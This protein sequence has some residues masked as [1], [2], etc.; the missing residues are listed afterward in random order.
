[1]ALVFA[2]M[3]PVPRRSE[4]TG[5]RKARATVRSYSVSHG[6]TAPGVV[7]VS[8]AALTYSGAA[9][10][11]PPTVFTR[12]SPSMPTCLTKCSPRLFAC[13]SLV[14]SAGGVPSEES[15]SRIASSAAA[16]LICASSSSAL[17]RWPSTSARSS[18]VKPRPSAFT[19]SAMSRAALRAASRCAL[20]V[21]LCTFLS[22]GYYRQDCV[23]GRVHDWL[24]RLGPGGLLVV[25]LAVPAGF[26]LLVCCLSRVDHAA[27]GLLRFAQRVNV[28]LRQYPISLQSGCGGLDGEHFGVAIGTDWND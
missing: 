24:L 17:A 16:A 22:N 25:G 5:R 28:L 4:T 11:A 21:M 13:G 27:Y 23:H 15:R 18:S 3:V 7:W 10:V 8:V 9:T 19:R 12:S 1:M 14:S 6:A 26:R 20:M 2:P